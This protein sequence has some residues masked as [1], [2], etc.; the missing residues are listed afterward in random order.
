MGSVFVA[1]HG[2]SPRWFELSLLLGDI[3]LDREREMAIYPVNFAKGTPVS[4]RALRLTDAFAIKR[5]SKLNLKS[6]VCI[7]YLRVSDRLTTDLLCGQVVV[8]L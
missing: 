2:G 4:K 3:L 7:S 6:I 1:D 5:L 8:W